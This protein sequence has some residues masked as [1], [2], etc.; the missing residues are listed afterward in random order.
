M[1]QETNP[2]AQ[3]RFRLTRNFALLSAIVLLMMALALS[4]FYRSWAVQQMEAEAEQSNVTAARLLANSLWS[5]N[6]DILPRL[7]SVPPTQIAQQ[8]E[9]AQLAMHIDGLIHQASIFKVKIYDLSGHTLFS[10]DRSQ[11][12]EDESDDIAARLAKMRAMMT[13]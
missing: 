1:F 4:F 9:L 13:A 2:I 11:I 10:T 3:K 6:A 5:W 12:G 8:P 7:S